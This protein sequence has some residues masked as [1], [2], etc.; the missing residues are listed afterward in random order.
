MKFILS[1][2]GRAGLIV[3]TAATCLAM[4]WAATSCLKSAGKYTNAGA[5]AKPSVVILAAA[6]NMRKQT[7]LIQRCCHRCS[8][9]L[10]GTSITPVGHMSTSSD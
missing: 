5:V 6:V 9:L 8:L 10:S 1:D 2:G 7:M 4:M 3:N